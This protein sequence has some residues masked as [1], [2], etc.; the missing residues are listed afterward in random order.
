MRAGL[1]ERGPELCG[2]CLDG[3]G[4]G[5]PLFCPAPKLIE[6]QLQGNFELIWSILSCYNWEFCGPEMGS[7]SLK[8]TQL[9][10]SRVETRMNAII[11]PQLHC[12]RCT[13]SLK[14]LPGLTSNSTKLLSAFPHPSLSA[15]WGHRVFWSQKDPFPFA[16]DNIRSP[17]G[18]IFSPS[19][20]GLK[21]GLGHS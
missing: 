13:G 16:A 14:F 11:F 6:G 5:A 7:N 20:A 21:L 4:I 12:F 8:V 10:S 9:L 1:A 19:R 17:F 15:S 18:K 2:K 3:H